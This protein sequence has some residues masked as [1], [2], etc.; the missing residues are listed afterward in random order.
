MWPIAFTA[1][2]NFIRNVIT[3]ISAVTN[4]HS[5]FNVLDG[6]ERFACSSCK[7]VIEFP[8]DFHSKQR[9][10]KTKKPC[11]PFLLIKGMLF[12]NGDTSKRHSLIEFQWIVQYFIFDFYVIALLRHEREKYVDYFFNK[13]RKRYHSLREFCS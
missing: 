9:D 13:Q 8:R 3:P 11:L 12:N 7:Q 1:S 4:L 10:S 6:I 5:R 2:N